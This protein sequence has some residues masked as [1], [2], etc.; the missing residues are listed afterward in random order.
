MNSSIISFMLSLDFYIKKP[1]LFKEQNE[2]IFNFILL[3]VCLLL[4]FILCILINISSR[5][6]AWI[7]RI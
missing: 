2:F 6:L 1:L 5:V 3:I 4:Y 7:L